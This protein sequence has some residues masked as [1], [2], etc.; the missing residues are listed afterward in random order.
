[1]ADHLDPVALHQALDD[2]A[3]DADAADLLDLAPGDGLAI[4]DECQGLEGGPGIAGGLF[5]PQAGDPLGEALTHLEAPAAAH[6]LQFDAAAF[7]LPGDPGQGIANGLA[8][9]IAVLR[10]QSLELLDAQRFVGR[11]QHGLEDAVEFR[12]VHSSFPSLAL[13]SVP[14]PAFT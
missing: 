7:T 14:D 8:A 11:E 9:G 2:L 13:S 3:A 1:M 12:F 4:G 5:L 6:F 10:E